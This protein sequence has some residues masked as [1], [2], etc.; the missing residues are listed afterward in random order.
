[1][2][3]VIRWGILGTGSIAATFAGDLQLLPDHRLVAVG[4]RQE[5]SA[6][7]FASR[8]E[9]PD[10]HRSYEELC[11]NPDVDVVYVA[12]PH[13]FH[14]RDS[15]LALRAGKPVLC[16]KPFTVNAAEAAEVIA[17]ARQHGLFCMEAMWTRFL[18][19]M[20]QI[21][22]LL[23]SG[24]L[25]ET[26]T[27][28]ADHGQRFLPPALDSRLY[29][30]ELAGGALLDLGIYPLSLAFFVL[31]TP[32]RVTAVSDP[33]VTGV[34]AQTSIVLQYPGGSHA[35]LTT[36]LGA[37][38]PTT[39][40]VTGTDGRVDIDEIWYAPT[41]FTFR[42][43]SGATQRFEE[44]QIGR[45][46]RYQAAEVGRCLRAGL[47]ESPVMSLDETLAIMTTM[48]EI[49]RQIGLHYPFES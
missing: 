48:D 43:L 18:P 3:D 8:F 2:T 41:S 25:G 49:R 33:T 36:T 5:S 30:P 29:A 11:A 46:L 14:A 12:T 38:T 13:P 9:A 26:R 7:E 23:D 42:P 39:A 44:P 4:S 27:V 40:S 15:L 10:S 45:G 19:H 47:T 35:V 37:R 1:M 20:R 28:I 16:E 31:G 22:E 24:A 32:D 17:A 21:R 6:A 34:D